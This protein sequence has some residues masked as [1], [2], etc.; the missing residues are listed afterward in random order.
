MEQLGKLGDIISEHDIEERGMR[1]KR[2][3]GSVTPFAQFM[4]N[5]LSEDLMDF[6]A[7]SQSGV[8]YIC[9]ICFRHERRREL[10]S[11]EPISVCVRLSVFAHVFCRSSCETGLHTKQFTNLRRVKDGAGPTMSTG[12]S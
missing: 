6:R 4:R 2:E 11:S 10:L 5:S 8:I 1:V 7:A 3:R 9:R 12:L